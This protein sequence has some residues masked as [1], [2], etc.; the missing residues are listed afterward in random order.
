M[1]L[2]RLLL[3]VRHVVQA[4]RLMRKVRFRIYDGAL[5]HRFVDI[6]SESV[7]RYASCGFLEGSQTGNTRVERI[8][9]GFLLS[10]LRRL[11]NH[12]VNR[13]ILSA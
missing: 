12:H 4:L 13:G 2:A 8:I 3:Q 9:D 10:H 6:V 7:A 1:N 5:S 11:P